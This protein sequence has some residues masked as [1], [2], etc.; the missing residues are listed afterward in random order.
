M[1]IK[2]LVF[3]ISILIFIFLFN[4]C[5]PQKPAWKGSTTTENGVTIVKNPKTP[6]YDKEIIFIEEVLSIGKTEGEDEYMFAQL[7]DIAVDDDG[8]IYTLDMKEANVKKFSSDGE[9]LTSFGKKGQGPGEIGLGAYLIITRQNEIVVE[10]P[11]NLRFAYFSFD[12]DFIKNISY[13]KMRLIQIECDKE[14]NIIGGTV[15]IEKQAYEVIKINP[16]IN[17]L[18]TYGSSPFPSN[19]QIH[20]PFRPMLRWAV[21]PDDTVVC[22]NGEEYV[23]ESFNPMGEIK[24]KIIKDYSPVKITEEE[25]AEKKKMDLQGRELEIPSRHGPY[26]WFTADDREEY[27][28]EPLSRL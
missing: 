28:L 21:L 17:L 22:G 2:S 12:G 14:G 27:S 9:L 7:R 13:A 4:S 16:E 6:L 11:M 10:D 26:F 25:I 8:N 23:L 19:P 20:N 24:K 18:C 15:N 1:K 5:G 3:S